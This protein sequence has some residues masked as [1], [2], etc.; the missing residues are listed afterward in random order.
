M[1]RLIRS[2][3]KEVD[4]ADG[5]WLELVQAYH[6]V[7]KH[8][9]H[10]YARSLGYLDWATQPDPFRRYE[11]AP[12]LALDLVEPAS[13]GPA[14]DALFVPG[15]VPASE[16]TRRS[17]SQLLYDSLALSAWKHH[18][19]SRWSLR[20]NP[21][22][23][24]LHPTEGYLVAGPVQGLGRTPAVYHYAPH[25]HG[26]E[27]RC[28]L[29][30]GGWEAL[31]RGLPER[32]LL[33]G[34]S[35][36]WWREAWKY[37][38]RAFRYCQHDLGHAV[39][40]VCV[41]AAALGWQARLLE[42]LPDAQIAALLGIAAQRGIEAEHPEALLVVWPQGA[43]GSPQTQGP[44]SLPAE[45]LEELARARWLG[46]PNRLSPD[47][48]EWE[49]LEVVAE[50]SAKRQRPGPGYWHPAPPSAGRAA[51]PPCA[52]PARRVIRQR[53]SA[54]DLDGK[55]RLDAEALDRMLQR[56][57]PEAGHPVFA[58]LPWKS[59]V[60]L[61]L[62]VH[63]VDGREPGLYVLIREPAALEPL[64]AQMSPDFAWRR[65]EGCPEELPLFLLR[66]GDCRRTAAAVSCGQDIAAD[67]AFAVAMLARFEEPLCEHGPWFYRRL[68]WEAGAIGQVL[69]LEAE[70]AGVRGT[71]IGCFFDEA[72]HSAFGLRGR[73][74]HDLYHFTV[75]GPVED[76]RLRSAP[77][78]AHLASR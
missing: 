68:H 43:N 6:A 14:Y 57:L 27:L 34:L 15:A 28:E 77:A 53:R 55:T 5:R 2:K 52:V 67:G 38:E 16:L 44:D 19:A 59:C 45:L 42:G 47:H 72:T 32:S 29:S 36:I 7:T 76:P 69:Y 63:R 8:A 75:G 66:P 23:G 3:I 54:V 31:C 26:L 39:A 49:I 41:A 11:G 50:A 20:V 74:F 33:V 62:F 21:S 30:A 1:S 65:P 70:A 35:S 61:G 60:H 71:G 25:E 51:G 9:P 48:F 22:S 13:A 46:R 37:G 40:A 17:V 78:Y 18:Q 58:A 24:N 56:L 12:L 64:Q 73:S 4:V 10:A